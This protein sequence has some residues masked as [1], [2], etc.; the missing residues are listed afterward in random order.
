MLVLVTV[1]AFAV[2]SV[3]CTANRAKEYACDMLGPAVKIIA[4]ALKV[5]EAAPASIA[6]DALGVSAAAGCKAVF[7]D[8][9]QPVSTERF[10]KE[11]PKLPQQFRLPPNGAVCLT[12]QGAYTSVATGQFQATASTPRTSCE[13]S[14][15]VG[16][17]FLASGSAPGIWVTAY[18]PVMHR[19]YDMYCDGDYPIAC[20]G[21]D[22]AIVYLY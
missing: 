13:F 12:R 3:A 2:T 20:K 21:G 16:A 22:Q 7:V 8:D 6:L 9:T 11:N 15:N 10:L 5:T 1:I 4:L 18:S 19:I 14:I 17:A